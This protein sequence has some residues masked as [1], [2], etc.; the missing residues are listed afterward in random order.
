MAALKRF[1]D[2]DNDNKLSWRGEVRFADWMLTWGDDAQ[3][4]I[5]VHRI[6]LARSCRFFLGATNQACQGTS[7]DLG[8]LL[9]DLC[10]PLL[11]ILLDWIYEGAEAVGTLKDGDLPLLYSMADVLQCPSL[12]NHTLDLIEKRV[13]IRDFTNDE[14]PLLDAV[15]AMKNAELF[16]ELLPSFPLEALHSRAKRI[17]SEGG[18]ELAA[19]AMQ[20]LVLRLAPSDGESSEFIVQPCRSYSVGCSIRSHPVMVSGERFR[21]LVYPAG[22][23]TTTSD[24]QP[25]YVSAFVETTHSREDPVEEWETPLFTYEISVLKWKSSAQHMQRDY[26][27]FT[28]ERRDRGWHDLIKYSEFTPE[29]GWLR[30]GDE[31]IKFIFGLR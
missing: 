21:L 14:W 15:V 2:E 22:T 30:A 28:K 16:K 4:Q 23:L 20:H 27:K 17:A 25:K 31:A 18:V 13:G 26:F 5:H 10:R 19:V 1:R 24:G 3:T 6:I 9:P 11:G 29:S 8:K 12:K 7:T